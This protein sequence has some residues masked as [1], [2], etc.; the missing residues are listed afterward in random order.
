MKPR[1]LWKQPCRPLPFQVLV[2]L[3][4]RSELSQSLICSGYAWLQGNKCASVLFA[5][6]A[7]DLTEEVFNFF[8][9]SVKLVL[10]L[11]VLSP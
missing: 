8:Q 4:R 10:A 1:S 9:H 7:I 6:L 11:N 2:I 5:I 3:L